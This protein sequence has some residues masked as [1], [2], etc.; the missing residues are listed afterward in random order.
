MTKK[1]SKVDLADVILQRKWR[2]G[3]RPIFKPDTVI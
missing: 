2:E 1:L 3:L